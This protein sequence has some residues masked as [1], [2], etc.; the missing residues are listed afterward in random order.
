MSKHISISQINL[1]AL[2]SLK[3]RFS[4]VDTIEKLFKP[5]GLA[6]GSSFHAALEW[7]NRKRME[8][9]SVS[10]DEVI[11]IFKA[12]WYAQNFETIKFKA[13]D[14]QESL[15][16]LGQAMILKYLENLPPKRPV[17]IEM[18][19]EIPLVNFTTGEVLDLILKGVIDLIEED[20]V[21]VDHKTSA[22]V[23]D[24]TTVNDSL[25]LT[26]YSYA[27]RYLYQKPE[28][29][30]RIDNIV[31][32]KNP[33]VKRFHTSRTEQDHIRLFHIAQAVLTGIE[34]QVFFP[35]PGWACAD[36]EFADHCRNW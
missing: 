16:E 25:Q 17:E 29:G 21:I 33:Q 1:Y 18:E 6:F 35:C 27:Y 15:A 32:T 23:L 8:T 7:L 9:G 12:D 10:A 13:K 3:Y 22:R 36:C 28:K 2:C 24:E 30:L 5:A 34:S 19:F 26:A 31:K 11:K 4:Y 14:S 20:G